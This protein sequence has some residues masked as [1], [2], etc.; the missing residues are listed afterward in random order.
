MAIIVVQ[1]KWKFKTYGRKKYFGVIKYLVI[2]QTLILIQASFQ[3]DPH[4]FHH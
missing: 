3:S 1:E 2:S 4:N